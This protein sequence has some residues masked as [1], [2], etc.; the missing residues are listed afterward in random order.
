MPLNYVV[1]L[2]PN[3][4]NTISSVTQLLLDDSL[5]DTFNLVQTIAPYANVK[6]V[7]EPFT[8]FLRTESNRKGKARATARVIA[9]DGVTET[10]LYQIGSA[11]N[12]TQTFSIP[13]LTATF[14]SVPSGRKLRMYIH[15]SFDNR[16]GSNSGSMDVETTV[17]G[18]KV[19]INTK[20]IL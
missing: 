3:L 6:M 11:D 9:Y 12:D 19:A 8:I 16:R 10:Q 1:G 13:K 5:D 2:K 7:I 18:V 17:S 14:A 20:V 15:Y 4:N